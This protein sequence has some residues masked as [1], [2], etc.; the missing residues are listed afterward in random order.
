MYFIEIFVG[1]LSIVFTILAYMQTDRRRFIYINIAAVFFFGLSLVLKGGYIGGISTALAILLYSSALVL[2]QDAQKKIQLI[3]P[4][5]VFIFYFIIQDNPT[6]P[7]PIL[8]NYPELVA[9]FIPIGSAITTFAI[10]QDD[11]IRQKSIFLIGLIFWILYSL[12][13]QAYFAL[14]TDILGFAVMLVTLLKMIKESKL[15]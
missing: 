5:L 13:L 11:M 9:F 14:A 6:S 1:A 8:I 3:M 2:K 4:I 12:A 10:Y 7:L 15:S